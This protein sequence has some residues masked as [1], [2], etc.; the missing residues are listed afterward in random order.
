MQ[1]WSAQGAACGSGTLNDVARCDPGIR[2]TPANGVR[3]MT[4]SGRGSSPRYKAATVAPGSREAV[5]RGP[6]KP[7]VRLAWGSLSINRTRRPSRAAAPARWWQ[8]L[9]L[10]TPPFWFSI[11]MTAKAT[12]VVWKTQQG[13]YRQ[14]GEILNRRYWGVGEILNT[15]PSPHLLRIS[16]DAKHRR[17]NCRPSPPRPGPRGGRHGGQGRAMAETDQ[18]FR[19]LKRAG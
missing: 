19:R 3:W 4:W 11:V 6:Q 15:R 18:V 7:C 8:V 10:P 12:S 13:R 14:A 16:P 17:P 5:A 2:S 1:V 9:D